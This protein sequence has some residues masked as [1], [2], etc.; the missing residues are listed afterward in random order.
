MSV[1]KYNFWDIFQDNSD[2]SLSLKQRL[3]VNGTILE[4]GSTVRSGTPVGG[5]DFTI[6]RNFDVA[7]EDVDD[8]LNIK[9]FFRKS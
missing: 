8:T 1:N 7:A 2:G 6:Y 3:N 9:G 4:V 5:I